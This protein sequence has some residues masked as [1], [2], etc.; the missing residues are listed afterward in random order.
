MFLSPREIYFRSAA[1]EVISTL[2]KMSVRCKAFDCSSVT[3]PSRLILARFRV[4]RVSHQY[5]NISVFKKKLVL[6]HSRGGVN[7]AQLRCSGGPVR[8]VTW[9]RGWVRQNWRLAASYGRKKCCL[10]TN[11]QETERGVRKDEQP[12]RFW[13]CREVQ[14]AVC[15][16]LVCAEYG[17]LVCAHAS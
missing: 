12:C 9:G 4:R 14:C 2:S 16:E 10:H 11:M 6:S 17:E 7:G 5:K 13:R 8:C 1:L 15:A 3:L